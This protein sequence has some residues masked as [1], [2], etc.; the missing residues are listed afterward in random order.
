MRR[1][2]RLPGRGLGSDAT[3]VTHFRC[4][5]SRILTYHVVAKHAMATDVAKLKEAKTV[6]GSEVKVSVKD[7]K[8]K[9][10]DANVTKTDIMCE[11]AVIHVIDA[12]MLPK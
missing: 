12:V 5:Y 3:A 4:R 1:S 2:Q 11:N 8:V 6:Q 10:N 7:G 9:V